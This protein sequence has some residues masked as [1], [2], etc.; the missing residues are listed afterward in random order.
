MFY[1]KFC[2]EWPSSAW[3]E[4]VRRTMPTNSNVC[5]QT[6]ENNSIL[7]FCSTGNSKYQFCSPDPK[8]HKFIQQMNN[9]LPNLAFN[10][11]MVTS[12]LINLFS[13]LDGF[14]SQSIY[15][16]RK[17]LSASSL[18]LSDIGVPF[19]HWM[20]GNLEINCCL[21]CFSAISLNQKK[22]NCSWFSRGESF[23][24]RLKNQH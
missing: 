15:S 23:P 24:F 17:A 22:Y 9:M 20:L 4:D 10:V 16:L 18:S 11:N 3:Q 19:R 5:Q 1:T 2:K 21:L 13:H 14:S 7:H 6:W 12:L 8:T